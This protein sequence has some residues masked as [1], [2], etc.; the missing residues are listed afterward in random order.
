MRQDFRVTEAKNLVEKYFLT[1]AIDSSSYWVTMD[2]SPI[3]LSY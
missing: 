1:K 3:I 2:N